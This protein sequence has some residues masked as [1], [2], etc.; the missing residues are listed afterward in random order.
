MENVKQINPLYKTGSLYDHMLLL[1]PYADSRFLKYIAILC[2]AQCFLVYLKTNELNCVYIDICLQL[3]KNSEF[4][5]LCSVQ[6]KD[7]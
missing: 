6:L 2:D 7:T 1:N 3:K 5:P 4:N